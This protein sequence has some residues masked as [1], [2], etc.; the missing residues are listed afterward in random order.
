MVI[1]D[2]LVTTHKNI[3]RC[4]LKCL[5]YENLGDTL[6]VSH[7]KFHDQA[8]A[9]HSK[10]DYVKVVRTPTHKSHSMFRYMSIYVFY[11]FFTFL[12]LCR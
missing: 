7:Y 2:I 11:N 10:P 1:M 5:K 6:A 9:Q 3:I 4:R 8:G 12:L